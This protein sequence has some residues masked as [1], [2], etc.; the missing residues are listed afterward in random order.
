MKAFAASWQRIHLAPTTKAT[1]K[2]SETAASR[3]GQVARQSVDAA[4]KLAESSVD[5]ID[6][7]V[8]ALRERLQSL[9]VSVAAGITAHEVAIAITQDMERRAQE[10]RERI[11]TAI[12]FDVDIMCD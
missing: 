8:H 3:Q 12:A 9:R 1:R 5:G 7:L 2:M 4:L 11:T 6:R 10:I